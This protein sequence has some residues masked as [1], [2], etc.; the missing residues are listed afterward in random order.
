MKFY[1]S[2][3]ISYSSITTYNEFFGC[4]GISV[5][6]F[7]VSGPFILGGHN[8]INCNPFS[9]IVNVLDAIREGIQVL[10]RH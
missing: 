8:F 4:L 3:W 10:F 9:M 7:G 1:K 2:S 6:W 5:R